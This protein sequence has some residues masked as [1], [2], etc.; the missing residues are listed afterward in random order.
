M[1][2]TELH[3]SRTC[4][5][6]FWDKMFNFGFNKQQQFRLLLHYLGTL[7]QLVL[8]N[9]CRVLTITS[10]L[11]SLWTLQSDN[12]HQAISL[13]PSSCQLQPGGSAGHRVATLESLKAGLVG[14]DYCLIVLFRAA[15]RW[16]GYNRAACGLGPQQWTLHRWHPT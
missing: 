15:V 10:H 14:A 4:T 1:K 16:W 3:K 11:W 2:M 5:K 13:R 9:T 12:D 8:C 6:C 7:I